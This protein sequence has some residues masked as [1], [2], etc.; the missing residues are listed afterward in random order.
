MHKGLVEQS[1]M[2]KKR[3]GRGRGLNAGECESHR[4]KA[5]WVC[6]VIVVG[7]LSTLVPERVVLKLQATHDHPEACSGSLNSTLSP[8]PPILPPHRHHFRAAASPPSPY[9]QAPPPSSQCPPVPRLCTHIDIM[10]SFARRLLLSG[11]SDHS[12]L[13]AS[14]TICIGD[15]SQA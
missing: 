14:S 4:R 12:L 7:G 5:P 10:S 8:S 11:V 2:E 9:S 1:G 3:E 15:K 13:S 6:W